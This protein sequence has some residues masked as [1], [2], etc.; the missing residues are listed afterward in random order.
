V[1]L[2]AFDEAILERW[3]LTKNHAATLAMTPIITPPTTP[4]A[5][6]PTFELFE[7]EVGDEDAVVAVDEVVKDAD[8]LAVEEVIELVDCADAEDSGASKRM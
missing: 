3:R 8:T 2:K 5:R 1:S 4:P 7:V 6:A